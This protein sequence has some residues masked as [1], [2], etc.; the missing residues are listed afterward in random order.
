MPTSCVNRP[1]QELVELHSRY[2]ET[3][4]PTA[5]AEL[6][7]AY[8]GLARSV[9]RRFAGRGE[10][11][12]D[13]IQVGF[14]GLL[15][16]LQRF[17]PNRGCPFVGFAVPTIAGELKKHF[18]DRRW[19]IRVPRGLRE[20]YLEVRAARNRLA[21][22]L[23]RIPTVPDI[24]A[25]LGISCDEVAEAMEAGST[26]SMPS[27]DS[28]GGYAMSHAAQTGEKGYDAVEDKLLVGRLLARVPAPQREVLLLR[29]HG[30][31]TQSE[32]GHRLGMGQ[33]QVSRVLARTLSSLQ[34][35]AATGN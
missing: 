22:G 27:I 8:A 32:I 24:A 26:F 10:S 17:D 5:R 11:L 35:R 23:G 29:F 12:E 13:L 30:E 31:L 28:P 7:E 33:M 1:P 4:D 3:R 19:R 14:V 6:V 2:A 15:Q 9:A 18:R 21:Q 25:E 34:A 20:R 16:A